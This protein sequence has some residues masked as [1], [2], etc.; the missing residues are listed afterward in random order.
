M[1]VLLDLRVVGS[2]YPRH[3]VAAPA[4]LPAMQ[5]PMIL[6]GIGLVIFLPILVYT[7]GASEHAGLIIG[8][9]LL[10]AGIG[11]WFYETRR[12]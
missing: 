10:L 3:R 7:L 2:T 1:L 12:D 11:A 6:I 8:G 4:T 9:A 5:N